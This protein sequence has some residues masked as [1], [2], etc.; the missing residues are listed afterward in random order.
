MHAMIIE[1][2][3]FASNDGLMRMVW[4]LLRPADLGNLNAGYYT[5][6]RT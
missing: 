4:Q 5:S 1:V 2:M 3:I 6:I